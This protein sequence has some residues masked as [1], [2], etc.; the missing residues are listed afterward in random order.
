MQPLLQP[1]LLPACELAA[2]LGAGAAVVPE[3]LLL[4]LPLPAGVLTAWPSPLVQPP[5]VEATTLSATQAL[6]AAAM[7]LMSLPLQLVV[8]AAVVVGHLRA[9]SPAAAGWDLHQAQAYDAAG[10]LG[11]AV[12]AASAAAAV[13]V[14]ATAAAA[15]AAAVVAAV[16]AAACAGHASATMLLPCMLL[17]SAARPAFSPSCPCASFAGAGDVLP[18]GAFMTSL[19][20]FSDAVHAPS[21]APAMQHLL[22]TD[23]G[24]WRLQQLH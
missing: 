24:P 15:P 2:A 14:A 13:V 4:L 12:A 8:A 16:V 6:V 21:A 3:V 11:T 19:P 22:L 23:Q 7:L 5:P 18:A 17:L 20:A 10:V 1:P 9:R